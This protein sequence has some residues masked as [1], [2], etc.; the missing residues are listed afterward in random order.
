MCGDDE[1]STNIVGYYA[2]NGSFARYCEDTSLTA[3]SFPSSDWAAGC[4]VVF[5]DE[6]AGESCIGERLNF[7]PASSVGCAGDFAHWTYVTCFEIGYNPY[8]I[9]GLCDPE[10]DGDGLC[11]CE[12]GWTGDTCEEIDYCTVECN[13]GD[14]PNDP[15]I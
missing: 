9:N 12:E 6:C 13:N 2:T 4:E 15:G 11:T 8:C 5:P 10:L 14:C 1:I 3:G 7:D